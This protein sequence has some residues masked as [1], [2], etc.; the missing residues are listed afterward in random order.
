MKEGKTERDRMKER[1]KE[2]DRIKERKRDRKN[3]FFVQQKWQVCFT[4]FSSLR[5]WFEINFAFWNYAT[6][7]IVLFDESGYKKCQLF[8]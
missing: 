1:K 5:F 2:R 8:Q 3:L 6:H 4:Y 7:D